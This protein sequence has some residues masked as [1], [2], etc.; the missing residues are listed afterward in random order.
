MEADSGTISLDNR[1]EATHIINPE[2][3]LKWTIK[4]LPQGTLHMDIGM[5]LVTILGLIAIANGVYENYFLYLTEKDQ[6]TFLSLHAG[7][8][9]TLMS[10]YMWVLVVRQKT[11]YSYTITNSLGIQETR[12]HFPKT[13]GVIFKIISFA[14][15][16]FII[17]LAIYEK[18]FILMLAGPAG[19][20]VV[21]AKFFLSWENPPKIETSADWKNYKYVTVDKKRKIILAQETEFMVGFEAKLPNELFD[22]YLE[23]LRSLLPENAIFTETDMKW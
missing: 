20:T 21:A 15:L 19:M 22:R 11:A 14:F 16:I 8:V 5:A 6:S 13:A 23:T 4:A 7:I 17:G 2:I 3:L 9:W 12:L 10:I 1:D 18:S